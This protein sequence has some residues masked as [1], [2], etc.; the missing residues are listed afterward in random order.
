MKNS[1]LF[2]F[3]KGSFGDSA[4]HGFMKIAVLLVF[5]LM[6][7][8]NIQNINAQ[9]SAPAVG[10]SNINL[11]NFGFNS[12]NDAA[13]IEYDN[14]VSGFHATVV[15]NAD[16]SFSCWGQDMAKDA[17][18]TSGDNL[19][20]TILNSI[21][22]PALTGTPLKAGIGSYNNW[23]QGILLTT[24]GLFAW[25]A[26]ISTT[27]APFYYTVLD[28]SLVTS[29]TFQK[30]T[31]GGEIDGLPTGVDPADVKMMFVSNSVIAI[32]TCSGEV[33]VLSRNLNSLRGDGGTSGITW[34]KVTTDAVGNP[35][36]TGVVACRGSFSSLMALKAD[37][38]MWIWG[39]KII[40]GDGTAVIAAQARATQ[41]TLP[42]GKTVK[43]FGSNYSS[44]G[45][46]Y[47]VLATDGNLYA[48]GDNSNK[49][50]GDW[51]TTNRLSWVQPRYT[52][53]TGQVM[54][55]IKWIS[56]QEHEYTGCQISVINANQT[57]YSWGSNDERMLGGT[58]NNVNVDP[59]IPSGLTVADKILTVEQGGHTT[60]VVKECSPTF[61]YVG[62]RRDGSMGNGSA[63][64]V[65]ESSY[66]FVTAA[67][68]ICGV[69]EFDSG[70][71]PSSYENSNPATH[72][73]AYCTTNP[74]LGAT[75][76]NANFG[77]NKNVAVG[78]NNT[79]AN[80]DGIEE[81]GIASLSGYTSSGTFTTSVIA[82][83]NTGSPIN[84]YAWVDWNNNGTF[85]A[86]EA[87]LVAVPTSATAQTIA[88]TWTG[89]TGYV[90]G[91][92][93]LRLRLTAQ[94]L[95]DNVATTSIDERSYGAASNGEV[96]D[97]IL[98]TVGCDLNL[99]VSPLTQT[100]NKGELVTYT[101][102]LA[103]STLIADSNVSVKL[104][105]PKGVSYVTS[106]AS[107]GSYNNNTKLW[108]IGTVAAS[109]THTIT[110][111]C[112]AN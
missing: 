28:P 1:L 106:T 80:G 48:C 17:S 65:F 2:L 103:N 49:G 70:D 72:I 92:N 71:T 68:Q 112:R 101:Y 74:Y 99:S 14:L 13:S 95:T 59:F 18:T 37:G 42:V 100:A 98:P 23:N 5:L 12:T 25:G 90:E 86:N 109:A 61:G 34:A 56:P 105:L 110:V 50:L 27:G 20:P 40:K 63:A 79:G 35:A 15:R 45:N 108:T 102:T 94:A 22:Y 29:T 9:C 81:D 47:Y 39:D 30:L 89:I 4:F 6:G 104:R 58:N 52:S 38:T 85:E 84:L 75:K 36:L 8:V 55:N 77:S 88:V 66:T 21:N 107:Q 3:N 10:C 93:Y 32:T 26:K 19:S 82:N 31:I 57:L 51:T 44:A 97:Y 53:A 67:V 78:S 96:E 11:S 87:V 16:G 83:N 54:D 73:I 33:W 60:M 41:M 64:D 111:T 7:F 76:P 43:M 69:T 62:H 46:A 91:K 24:T